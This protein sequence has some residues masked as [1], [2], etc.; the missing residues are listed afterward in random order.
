MLARLMFGPQNYRLF[1]SPGGTER[2]ALRVPKPPSGLRMSGVTTP[3]A[4]K[5]FIPR[6]SY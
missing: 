4:Q 6:S 1:L 2:L 5:F 3:K